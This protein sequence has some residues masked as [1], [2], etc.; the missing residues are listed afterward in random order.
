MRKASPKEKADTL[1]GL[2]KDS[3]EL[4]ATEVKLSVEGVGSVELLFPCAHP[5]AEGVR[6]MLRRQDEADAKAADGL[7]LPPTQ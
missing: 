3:Y 7:R 4:G 1:F 6:E 5:K 2:I